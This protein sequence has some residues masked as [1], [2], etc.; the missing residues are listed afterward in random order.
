MGIVRRTRSVE[1]LLGVFEQSEKAISVVDLVSQLQKEMN[2]TTVYRILDKLEEDGI[3]HSFL[4]KEGLKWY[5]K[6][7]GCSSGHHVDAHP[8]FQCNNCGTIECLS[9]D[10]KIPTVKDYQISSVEIMLQ[11]TCAQCSA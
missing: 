4:G 6:C 11:G 9:L 1:T 10:V 3:V 5:A 7:Q 8:H 2:K